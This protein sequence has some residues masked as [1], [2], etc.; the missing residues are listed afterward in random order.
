MLWCLLWGTAITNYIL[1]QTGEACNSRATEENTVNVGGFVNMF[2][3]KH[4]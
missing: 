2:H 3:I 4:F 1:A